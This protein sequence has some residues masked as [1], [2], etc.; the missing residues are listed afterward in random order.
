[1]DDVVFAGRLNDV[2]VDCRGRG[3]V[4]PGWATNV[5]L[6]AAELEFTAFR[7]CDLPGLV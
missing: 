5:D 4:E 6:S 1:M 7:G 2:T 3:D